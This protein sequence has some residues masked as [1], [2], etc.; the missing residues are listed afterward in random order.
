MDMVAGLAG[1][2]STSTRYMTAGVSRDYK[3]ID[4]RA[5]YY[6]YTARLVLEV[7]L[8]DIKPWPD[9][10]FFE[11]TDNSYLLYE[12][13]FSDYKLL[14]G[15]SEW[16]GLL[17]FISSFIPVYR[18]GKDPDLMESWG[19]G[20]VDRAV[21]MLGKRYDEKYL[22]QLHKNERYVVVLRY[23]PS[24]QEVSHVGD[25]ASEPWCDSMILVEGQPDDYLNQD[26]FSSLKKLIEMTEAD[27][28]TFDMVYTDDMAFIPR[29]SEKK[30]AISKGRLLTMQDTVKHANVCVVSTVFANAY[31]LDIGDTFSVA[32]S[33]V[34]QPQ[35]VGLGAVAS[36]PNRYAPPTQKVTLE[37]VGIYT[38]LDTSR[39][40]AKTPNWAY[41]SNTVFLPLS[42][43]PTDK[44]TVTVH[45]IKPGEFSFVIG[46][47]WDVAPFLERNKANLAKQGLTLIMSDGG[48]LELEKGFHRASGLALAGVLAMSAAVLVVV[49]LT[50]Y[51]FIV[52]KKKDFAI[53]RALGTPKART[54]GSLFRPLISLAVIAILLGSTLAWIY[55]EHTIARSL[56][57]SYDALSGQG[58]NAT[59]PLPLALICVLGELGLLSVFAALG[60]WRISRIPPLA[61]LQAGRTGKQKKAKKTMPLQQLSTKP[62]PMVEFRL[63]ERLP[64]EREYGVM[65]QVVRYIARHSRRAIVKSSLTVLLSA[66]LFGAIAQFAAMRQANKQLFDSFTIKATYTNGLDID[67]ALEIIDSGYVVDPYLE[68]SLLDFECNDISV[69]V[70][71]T[72]NLQRF[73]EQAVDVQYAVGYDAAIMSSADAVC[74][75]SEDLLDALGLSVG[76]H[77]RLMDWRTRKSISQF[78]GDRKYYRELL[79]SMSATYTIVGCMS[80]A[81]TDYDLTVYIPA[82]RI[83]KLE[84]VRTFIPLELAEYTLLRNEKAHEFQK[85]AEQ[86]LDFAGND[87]GVTLVMDTTQLDKVGDSMK[88]Y[89]ILFPVVVMVLTLLGGLLSG[90]MILQGAKEASI[91][92]VLGTTKWR[93][94]AMLVMEPLLLSLLG[95]GLGVVAVWFFNGGAIFSSIAAMLAVCLVLYC[96]VCTIGAVIGAY[97]VTRAKVLELLQTKE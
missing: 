42:L 95:L 72:N 27:T 62:A 48:W 80:N 90:L 78:A 94:R 68:Y 50:I 14:A 32:L 79:M 56:V 52:R 47:A 34:L 63:P 49:W 3:R 15:D 87:D 64:I 57:H 33:D 70:R 30:M 39:A 84:N 26:Q 81:E 67:Q 31:K 60:L 66:L 65:R 6:N 17:P 18:E 46:D 93:T 19:T 9:N 20:Y 53:M 29:F 28:H 71:M 77:V 25:R 83:L 51:L 69:S 82:N 16:S 76:A 89:N 91:L 54:I 38:D 73:M 1:V 36:I 4:D 45:E 92:R 96:A 10:S 21:S 2:T 13:V 23:D 8:R 35:H 37:I 61:L 85:Y 58:V 40:Q 43:L 86:R 44:A 12:L 88:L 97:V 5:D 55:T 41:S 75:V 7:T 11:E 59:V 24:R 22:N 74:I